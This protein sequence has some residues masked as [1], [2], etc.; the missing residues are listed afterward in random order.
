MSKHAATS[1]APAAPVIRTYYD[2]LQPEYSQLTAVEFDPDVLP[3][4]TKQSDVEESDINYILDRFQ[5]TGEISS[6]NP[7]APRYGDFTLVPSYQEALH[8]V[9][10]AQV[11]FDELP[12]KVRDRF[13]NDPEEFLEF[14]SSPGNEA[15]MRGLGLLPPLEGSP[16]GPEAPGEPSNGPQEAS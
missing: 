6:S 5:R 14:V 3:S 10:D 9:R 4:M 16:D 15:E 8:L 7:I 12:S 1:S 2:G 11:A 13:H